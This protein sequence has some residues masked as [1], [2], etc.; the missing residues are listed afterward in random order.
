MS[1]T[2]P[3]TTPTRWILGL[4]LASTLVP[5][6]ST[7]IAVALSDIADDFDIAKGTAGLLVT[8][9]LGVMLVGQPLAG[10]L[11]DILGSR[12]FLLGSL[13][14]FGVCSV[15]ASLAKSFPLLVGGRVIQAIFGAALMPVTR[16]LIRQVTPPDQRG[17]NFGVQESLIAAGAASGP[18]IGGLMVEFTGWSGVFIVNLP[19]ATLAL[20]LLRALPADAPAPD[21][22]IASEPKAVGSPMAAI[23]TERSFLL[24]FG[25]QAAAVLAQYSLLLVVPVVL[26]A[27]GW[28]STSVGAALVLLTVG[29][30]V[31]GPIGGRVGD[32]I[33][34]RLPTLVGMAVAVIG[35]GLA[36]ATLY[37]TPAVVLLGMAIFG[38][39]FGLGVPNLTT[40]ALEAA[41]SHLAGSASGMWSMSRYMGSIPASLL[42]ATLL[43]DGTQGGQTVLAISGVAMLVAIALASRMGRPDDAR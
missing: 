37:T 1:A 11:A 3:R 39:G 29:M 41:P 21:T 4:G 22:S 35:V 12:R 6:N 43:G 19:I 38:L 25:A 36:A 13:L 24:P 17:R 42:F 18:L 34:R 40:S 23:L 26:D 27:R 7:M 15:L 31:S 10:R 2:G 8:V 28:S 32:R 16:A 33:G 9:Y 20:V 14:G 5:L 30:V